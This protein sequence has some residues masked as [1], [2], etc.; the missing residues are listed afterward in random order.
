MSKRMSGGKTL[1]NTAIDE[2]R[3]YEEKRFGRKARMVRLHARE[4]E[5]AAHVFQLLGPQPR[6]V[7]VPCGSGRFFDIFSAAAEYVMADLSANMLQVVRERFDL[8]AH[9]RLHEA[10]VAKIPLPDNSADLC[11][12]MRLFHHFPSDEMR[13]VALRELSRVSQ[14][15]VALSFYNKACLRYYWRKML[16]KKMRGN[17]ITLDHLVGLAKQVGLDICECMPRR[18]V[19]EHQ[20]LVIFKK[21]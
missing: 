14:T 1:E 21:S 15:Y 16:G 4:R 7:D 6:I 9:V 20:C 17:Y 2:A 8:P 18:N 5:F 13:L 19:L 11:F 3:A 10:N 12:C